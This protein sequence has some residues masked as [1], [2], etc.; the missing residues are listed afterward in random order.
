MTKQQARFKVKTLN[1]GDY[2][3][4]AIVRVYS[5]LQE[6]AEVNGISGDANEI[7]D[8][9]TSNKLEVHINP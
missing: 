4:T 2:N 7:A 3:K 5:S 9:I 8:Y 6:V 1:F